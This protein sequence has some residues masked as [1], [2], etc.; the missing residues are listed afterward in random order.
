MMNRC[1]PPNSRNDRDASYVSNWTRDDPTRMY[2]EPDEDRVVACLE[3]RIAN[4]SGYSIHHQEAIQIVRNSGGKRGGE[5]PEHN[6][7]PEWQPFD[8]T[9]S[10]RAARMLIALDTGSSVGWDVEFPSLR[11]AFS[12]R[13]NDARK[14]YSE[15][16]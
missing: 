9:A 7:W 5:S 6:L 10:K 4:I 16:L 13:K 3:T 2:L 8:T 11:K 15:T 1:A 14:S 12:I